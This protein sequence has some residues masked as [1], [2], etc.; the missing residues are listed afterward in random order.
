MIWILIEGGN[1]VARRH[2][3]RACIPRE[4]IEGKPM[5]NSIDA[6]YR[7]TFFLPAKFY[8]LHGSKAGKRAPGQSEIPIG[9]SGFFALFTLSSYSF[10]L[11]CS[12][13][14][15]GSLGPE[16]LK[17]AWNMHGDALEYLT[18]KMWVARRISISISCTGR[19]CGWE[20]WIAELRAR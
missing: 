4:S 6:D 12:C 10:F 16:G 5:D 3:G 20:I 1:S 14:F 11:S 7:L 19:I 9:L 17:S 13:T 15:F 8:V 18:G 2:A